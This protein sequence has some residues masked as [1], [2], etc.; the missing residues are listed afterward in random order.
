MNAIL[1]LKK[2]Q[3]FL[4]ILF[5]IV[6]ACHNPGQSPIYDTCDGNFFLQ[7]HNVS[8]QTI[9][10]KQLGEYIPEKQLFQFYLTDKNIAGNTMISIKIKPFKGKGIYRPGGSDNIL[11]DL[12]VEGA[13]DE[14]YQGFDGWL[15]VS[16]EKPDNLIAYYEIRLE[17]FYNKKIIHASGWINIPD[18]SHDFQ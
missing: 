1:F 12:Q 7:I 16:S 17:G 15:E 8:H 9:C 6:A 11:F 18:S 10:S 3:R 5:L 2:L 4:P 13:T 14:H